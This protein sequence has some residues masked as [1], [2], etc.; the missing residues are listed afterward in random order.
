M[1][2]FCSELAYSNNANAVVE[3]HKFESV[4]RNTLNNISP[5]R[6]FVENPLQITIVNFNE[7]I[8]NVM[9][10]IHPHLKDKSELFLSSL[11]EILFID[12]EDFKIE[13]VNKKYK[14]FAPGRVVR[15]KYGGL[16][17]YISHDE[18]NNGMITNINVSHHPERTIDEKVWG[19][20]HWV[21]YPDNNVMNANTFNLLYYEYPSNSN[22]TGSKNQSKVLLD[23]DVNKVFNNN[24]N[25]QMERIGYFNVSIDNKKITHLCSL[26]EDNKRTH[27]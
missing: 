5:R 18:D 21:S 2:A 25:Y 6:M 7:S 23:Y 17:K 22:I 1:K 4:I 16:I 10:P 3:Q 14:R 20:I 9:K 15:I 8:S 13:G 11:N 24:D 19:T 27:K 12:R 26:K